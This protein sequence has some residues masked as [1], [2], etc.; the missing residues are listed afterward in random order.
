MLYNIQSGTS[1]EL[2]GQSQ[3]GEAVPKALEDFSSQ[4]GWL[5]ALFQLKKVKER[6][7]TAGERPV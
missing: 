5:R 4:S 7:V 1:S 2:T 6:Q 3:S